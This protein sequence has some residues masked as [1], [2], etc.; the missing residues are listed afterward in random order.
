[1]IAE[2]P[3]RTRPIA[4]KAVVK[5]VAHA[6]EPICLCAKPSCQLSP[7]AMLLVADL[8]PI[9]PGASVKTTRRRAS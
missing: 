6:N 4:R 9:H 1:M 7:L 2:L 3:S 8:C 5:T